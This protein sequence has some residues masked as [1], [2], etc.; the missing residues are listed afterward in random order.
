MNMG[1][2]DQNNNDKAKVNHMKRKKKNGCE[3][4]EINLVLFHHRFLAQQVTEPLYSL[5]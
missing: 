4:I 1:L 2:R 5:N 3:K